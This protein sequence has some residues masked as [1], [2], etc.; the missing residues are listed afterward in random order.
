MKLII[1]ESQYRKLTEQRKSFIQ[2]FIETKFPEM[3]RL[4]KRQTNNRMFGRGHKYFDPKTNNVL[5]HTVSGGPVY[6]KSGG[7]TEPKYPGIRL[8]VDGT[9]YN[10]LENYLGNF[11][12]ELL[13]WF[14]ET[15]KQDADRVIQGIR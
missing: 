4:R 6:W 10:E 13:K 11:E 2:S 5:F 8:Y 3:G 9:L 1:T 12:D 15:Y 14:N 7:E